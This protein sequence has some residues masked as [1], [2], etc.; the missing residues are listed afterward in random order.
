MK[1][2]FLIRTSLIGDSWLMKFEK[3]T[4][5]CHPGIPAL[6]GRMPAR[7]AAYCWKSLIRLKP[8]LLSS[9]IRI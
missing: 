2:E 4:R 1:F 5:L 7:A 3:I 9:D 6:A 8:G